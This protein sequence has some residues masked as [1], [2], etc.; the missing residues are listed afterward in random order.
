MKSKWI[1][2]I[3]A[4]AAISLVGCG[5]GGGGRAID[6][7]GG[8]PREVGMPMELVAMSNPFVPDIPVPLGFSHA[9]KQSIDFGAGT[10]R[11]VHHMYRGKEDKWSVRRFYENQMP[12]NRWSLV[13]YMNAEGELSMDY[14]K[15][16]ERC[17]VIITS[18]SWVHPTRIIV[19]LWTSGPIIPPKV[20]KKTK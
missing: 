10:A 19:R 16:N 18:G 8:A 3:L 12:I 13:T 6:T 17:R 15:D 5:G 2:I 1:C 9:E 20:E 4:V 7:S 14:E 11:Y